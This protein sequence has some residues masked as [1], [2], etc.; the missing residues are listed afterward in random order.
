L[1][2][3]LSR[4]KGVL[5]FLIKVANRKGES[6]NGLGEYGRDKGGFGVNDASLPD[7]HFKLKAW[8]LS[9]TS[10]VDGKRVRRTA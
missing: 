3:D 1:P 7:I 5:K 2:I 4:G 10:K 9:G 6:D 8:E